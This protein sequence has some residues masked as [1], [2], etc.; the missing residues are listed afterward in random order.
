MS[1]KNDRALFAE[2]HFGDNVWTPGSSFLQ[3]APHALC[4]LP[5]S[6]DLGNRF[7]AVSLH[8]ERCS[9]LQTESE[10]VP[11]GFPRPPIERRHFSTLQEPSAFSLQRCDQPIDICRGRVN[12]A[13]GT[14]CGSRA[15]SLQK[16][17]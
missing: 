13:R 6:S 15:H 11:G 1:A 9:D 3:S 10:S 5:L 12:V 4:F 17:K 14:Y 7:F 16:R 8:P 2:N